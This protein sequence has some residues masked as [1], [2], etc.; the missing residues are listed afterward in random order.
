[1]EALGGNYGE[2]ALHARA[3]KCFYHILLQSPW[4]LLKGPLSRLHPRKLIS[5]SGSCLL[6]AEKALLIR[7]FLKKDFTLFTLFV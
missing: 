7:L 3:F 5:E 1:M 2:T 4:E 6:T